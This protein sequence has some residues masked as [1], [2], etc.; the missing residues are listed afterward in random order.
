VL[1]GKG[2]CLALG[3]LRFGV[4]LFD[5][6]NAVPEGLAEILDL[7]VYVAELIAAFGANRLV[8]VSLWRRSVRVVIVIAPVTDPSV[9]NPAKAASP[10]ATGLLV[11]RTVDTIMRPVREYQRKYLVAKLFMK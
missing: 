7:P 9:T 6:F 8:K 1:F 11:T 5:L 2:F 10:P 3:L 4:P